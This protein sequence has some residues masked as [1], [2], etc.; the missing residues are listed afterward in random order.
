MYACVIYTCEKIKK[1]IPL[2]WI[3]SK[4][5]IK[6]KHYLAYYSNN[7]ANIAPPS[8]A[9]ERNKGSSLKEN[10]VHTIWLVKI[11]G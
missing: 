11:V 3:Y 6:C 8:N 7:V 9:I 1:V 10:C 4:N 2:E 5:I